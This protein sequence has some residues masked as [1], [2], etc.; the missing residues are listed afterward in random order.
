MISD[1]ID[2]SIKAKQCPYNEEDQTKGAANSGCYQVHNAYILKIN[3]Y[4]L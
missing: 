4:P 3:R 2:Q 1:N